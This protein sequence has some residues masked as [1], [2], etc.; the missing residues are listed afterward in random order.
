MSTVYSDG[1]T[2][3]GD[4]DYVDIDSWCSQYDGWSQECCQCIAQHESGGDSHACNANTNGSID[5]GLWQINSSNW[6]SCSGGNPPC[7]PSDNLSCAQDIF[8]WGGNTWKYWSTCGMCNC[9]DI[10]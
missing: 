2:T 3:C 7:D 1:C 5:V 9:C 8:N 4:P 10:A 6:S